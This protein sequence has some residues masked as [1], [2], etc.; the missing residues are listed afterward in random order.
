[1]SSPLR[2]IIDYTPGKTSFPVWGCPVC[3]YSNLRA[4]ARCQNK[5]YEMGPTIPMLKPGQTLDHVPRAKA[6]AWQCEYVRPCERCGQMGAHLRAIG[7]LCDGCVSGN[8]GG[9]L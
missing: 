1:M 8:K 6:V 7:Y 9:R 2:P 5:R 3:G 4:V